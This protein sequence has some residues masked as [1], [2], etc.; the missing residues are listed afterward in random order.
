[1]SLKLYSQYLHTIFWHIL[2]HMRYAK[3][4]SNSVIKDNGYNEFTAITNKNVPIFGPNWSLSYI[5]VHSYNELMAIKKFGWPRDVRYNWVW[6]YSGSQ[7]GVRET[8]Q[9]VRLFFISLRFRLRFQL[10]KS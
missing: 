2:A 1:M 8:Y 4:Q 3:V 6:L 9:G 5:N 7:P 10:N